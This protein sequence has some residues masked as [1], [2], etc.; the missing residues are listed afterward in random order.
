MPSACHRRDGLRGARARA[1]HVGAGFNIATNG[2]DAL[3]AIDA[4]EATKDLGIPATRISMYNRKARLLGTAA[5][6]MPRP[7]AMTNI[8]VASSSQWV[9]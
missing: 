6:G 9:T 5:T 8:T 1:E 3:A 7:G 4:L 2:L